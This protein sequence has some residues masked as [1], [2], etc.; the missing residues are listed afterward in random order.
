MLH[1]A[2]VRFPPGATVV[3]AST[4][5]VGGTSADTPT[6]SRKSEHSEELLASIKR[7][8]AGR[9]LWEVSPSRL[10]L[11]GGTMLVR[12]RG[13]RLAF[14]ILA[15]NALPGGTGARASAS[16]A[17]TAAPAAA[18]RAVKRRAGGMAAVRDVAPG[19]VLLNE[20]PFLLAS[21]GTARAHADRWRAYLTMMGGE[22][23]TF[24][25]TW[26]D[27]T[28]IRVLAARQPFLVPFP[29]DANASR[30]ARPHPPSS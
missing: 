10:D 1:G 6:Q 26:R 16:S 24:V 30:A 11:G 17:S 22:A 12:E 5:A 9:D 28:C 27:K 21:S 8:D 29:L 15:E 7:Y 23:Y 3:V 20:R 4:A 25:F 14:C 2:R 19:E 18:R 13:M